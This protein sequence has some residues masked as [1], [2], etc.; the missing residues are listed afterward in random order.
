MFT[1]DNGAETTKHTSDA[2]F[3]HKDF[4]S[5]F[6]TI[7]NSS[8]AYDNSSCENDQNNQ[9]SQRQQYPGGGGGGGVF[10]MLLFSHYNFF[11]N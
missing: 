6:S 2:C 3:L 5:S 9:I 11:L 7:G 10:L 4:F 1:L 8:T